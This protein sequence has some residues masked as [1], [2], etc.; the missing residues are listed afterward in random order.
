MKIFQ[1]LINKGDLV[2]DVGANNGDKSNILLQLGAR[3]VA[4]EPQPNCVKYCSSRFNGNDNFI[5]NNIGLDATKGKTILYEANANTLSSMSEDFIN[6]VK[7]ERFINYSWDKKISVKVDTLDNMILKYG[8]PKFIKID[9]EGYEL[10]VLKGLSTI[11]HVVSIEFT[12]ELISKSLACIKH[13][14]N[15]NKDLVFNYGYREDENFKYDNWISKSEILKYLKSVNDY[16]F[17][18]G[19]IYIKNL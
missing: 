13:L 12:P 4:F 7:K 14:E 2:F 6:V 3:V 9:V 18:F 5:I 8:K 16:I 15:L 10:N 17:E 19:D 1:S 11:V